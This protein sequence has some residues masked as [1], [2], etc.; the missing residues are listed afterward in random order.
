MKKTNYILYYK[1]LALFFML[2]QG[3]FGCADSCSL[4]GPFTAQVIA[5]GADGAKIKSAVF[6]AEQFFFT[7][8]FGPVEQSL[9]LAS[10]PENSGRIYIAEISTEEIDSFALEPLEMAYS[11]LG[12]VTFSTPLDYQE[13]E[14]QLMVISWMDNNDDD[15]LDLSLNG[16]SEQARTIYYYNA[17][18]GKKYYLCEYEMILNTTEE[19]AAEQETD[20]YAEDSDNPEGKTALFAMAS[21]CSDDG[22]R[23]T[24][25]NE[26]RDKWMLLL[27]GREDLPW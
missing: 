5:A 9:L 21:A 12:N 2:S 1:R 16:Y 18:K 26:D 3:L 10:S 19:D 17:E 22:D 24:I 27:T 23:M 13:H 6:A 8:D 7:D 4:N 20:E 15:L 11:N 25:H 14:K